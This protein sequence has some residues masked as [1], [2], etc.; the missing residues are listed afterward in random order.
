MK[1]FE[2]HKEKDV[3]TFDSSDDEYTIMKFCLHCLTKFAKGHISKSN[4]QN[5]LSE[6]G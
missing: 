3:L 2:C 4:Y 1:C 6:K 5:D